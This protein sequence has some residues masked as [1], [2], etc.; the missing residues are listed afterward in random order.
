MITRSEKLAGLAIGVV[1]AFVLVA[2]PAGAQQK[3]GQ[4]APKKLDKVQQADDEL[5]SK[6]ID[7]VMTP[8]TKTQPPKDFALTFDGC[9][10]LKAGTGATYVPYTLAIEP[11][12][13]SN[14]AVSLLVRI[15]KKGTMM[16]PMPKEEPKLDAPPLGLATDI[17]QEEE[18][19][20]EK[21][22]PRVTPDFEDVSFFDLK[23]D[24]AKFNRAFQVAP[25]EYD[26]YVA[27]KERGGDKKKPGKVTLFKHTMVVPSFEEGLALSSVI[28]YQRADKLAGALTPDQQKEHPY[29][30]GNMELVLQTDTKY[31]KTDQVQFFFQVFNAAMDPATKKPNLIV[32]YSF[33]TKAA[34]A[35]KFFNATAEAAIDPP[36]QTDGKP[37]TIYRFDGVPLDSFAPGDYRLEI[38]VTD[39]AANKSVTKNFNFSI[40]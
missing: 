22:R 2:A 37:A 21:P 6:I 38:K 39:K 9:N 40:Q 18:P 3:P 25:G 4:P 17:R 10:F 7:D 5:L 8:G 33:Y 11:G 30:I 23:K 29:A 16:P 12:K 36:G 26:I 31:K 15:V 20:V 27:F 34:G 32:Q 24:Q 13:L 14:Q 1:I 28:M 19:V 35:E